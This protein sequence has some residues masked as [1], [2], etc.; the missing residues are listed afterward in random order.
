MLCKEEESSMRVISTNSHAV[1]HKFCSLC[2]RSQL[3]SVASV[4]RVGREPN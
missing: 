2:V 1:M 4:Q 3:F